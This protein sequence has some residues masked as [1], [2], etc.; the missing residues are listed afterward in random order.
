MYQVIIKGEKGNAILRKGM[1]TMRDNAA[2]LFA[3]IRDTHP[4]QFTV[5]LIDVH[6]NEVLK[7]SKG[8][9]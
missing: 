4:E 5:E 7:S 3:H 6:T 9:Q 1:S 8:T 2:E